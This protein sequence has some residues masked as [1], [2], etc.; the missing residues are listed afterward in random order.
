MPQARADLAE[1][2]RR[3]DVFQRVGQ[4]VRRRRRAV[5][6][7]AGCCG[8][9]CGLACASAASARIDRISSSRASFDIGLRDKLLRPTRVSARFKPGSARICDATS[10]KFGSRR[11]SGPIR[12]VGPS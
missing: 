8:V 6:S 3:I 1:A 2:A 12:F 11:R 7:A 5:A 10:A 9:V 4:R